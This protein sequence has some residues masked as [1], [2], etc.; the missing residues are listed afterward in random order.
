MIN[1]EAFIAT[2]ENSVNTMTNE[3][4]MEC[5]LSLSL[6]VIFWGDTLKQVPKF[7]SSEVSKFPS[8]GDLKFQKFQ[9]PK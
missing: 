1:D 5:K 3:V 9:V 2:V 8:S 7:P 4:C 6:R